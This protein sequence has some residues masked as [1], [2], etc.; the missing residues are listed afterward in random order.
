MPDE[1]LDYHFP[2]AGVHVAGPYGRQPVRQAR[3]GTYV[4]TAADG[5]NVRSHDPRTGRD[6]GGS[7]PG[8]SRLVPSQVAGTR[9]V[10][11]ELSALANTLGTAV[12]TSNSGRV[13]YLLAVSQGEVKVTTPE[14]TVW[15]ST[16]NLSGETPPLNFT[17]VM[18]S[19][20]LNQKMF[21]AD[22]TNYVF[23][24]PVGNSVNSWGQ[25][26]TAGLLPRDT[27]DNACRLITTWRGRL[28]M[29][30]LLLDPQNWFMSR[31]SDP[32]DWE[33]NPA[34]NDV[35]AAVA[36]NATERFG[37]IGDVVN[38]L[39]PLS[40]DVLMLLCDHTIHQIRG[41]P[42]DGGR[43]DLLS[44]ITGG[45]FGQAWCKDPQ[46]NAYFFGSKPSV[47]RIRAGGLPERISSPI[48]PLLEDV[49]T[50]NTNIRL[51]WDHDAEAVHLFLTTETDGV[52]N[53]DTHWVFETRSQ[54]WWKEVY[55]NDDHNPTCACEY[56]GNRPDDRRVLLGGWDGY[57]RL[58]DPDA[59]D[60]DGT[61]ITSS[62]LLGPIMTQELDEMLLKELQ[63]VLGA[64]SGQITWEV[65]PGE[66]AEQAISAAAF[67]S[68]FAAAGR[69]NTQPV[70]VAN[71]AM[72][73]RISSVVPW[74]MESLR[75]VF[76]GRGKVRRR[77]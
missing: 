60:D 18:Q 49:D 38:G 58:I 65:L 63:W 23:Y 50:G 43:I 64:N 71:H 55:G 21:Y 36:G 51:V 67:V 10:V 16:T 5:S 35:G 8:L 47:Y 77:N 37:L 72:Y 42:T 44:D 3:D 20:P 74:A 31:I 39:V 34:A 14:S 70:R 66:T 59:A 48:E 40:D 4:R 30:G 57:V 76:G 52:P 75:A 6:R 1:T 15:S 46:G 13:V 2:K 53:D 11:Q 56:D 33:Y 32:F 12:Q 29:S 69:N 54:S 27:A 41:D 25:A 73:V 19:S 7:R 17:G 45:A 62:V 24:N 9:W 22:G 28:V 68:G 26:M 61:A